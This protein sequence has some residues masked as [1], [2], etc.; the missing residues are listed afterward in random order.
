MAR[1]DFLWQLQAREEKLDMEALQV[2]KKILFVK[3]MW[4]IVSQSKLI[5]QSS[6]KRIL[7]NLLPAHVATHFLDNQF[8]NNLVKKKE[9]IQL[10]YK[11]KQCMYVSRIQ[12]QRNVSSFTKRHLSSPSPRIAC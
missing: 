9:T 1:L 7:F 11:R 6:N 2:G 10:I 8:R 12:R 3:F 4:D 5:F